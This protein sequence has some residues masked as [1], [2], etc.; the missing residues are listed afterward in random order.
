M[1][2]ISEVRNEEEALL[3]AGE[4]KKKIENGN[5]FQELV[6]EF[7]DDEGTK[8]SGGSLV[9]S[10]GNAFPEEFE[11][12]LENMEEGQVSNPIFLDTSIHLL[13]L[14]SIQTPLPEEYE[15]K[16]EG[17]QQSLVEEAANL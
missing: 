10:D 3:L 2:N 14:T 5:D 13:K 1:L 7:S 12:A 15:L 11:I 4:I 9:V 8:N 6:Q 16:K 17:I